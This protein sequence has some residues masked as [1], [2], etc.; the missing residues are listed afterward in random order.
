MILFQSTSSQ[1]AAHGKEGTIG[2]QKLVRIR[3][4]PCTEPELHA[5]AKELIVR[6]KRDPDSFLEIDYIGATVF[7][8]GSMRIAVAQPPFSDGMEITAVRPIAIVRL[9]DYRMGQELKDRL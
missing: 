6:T 8:I 9:D 2:N 3:N 1:C 4:E 7:Q 5:I